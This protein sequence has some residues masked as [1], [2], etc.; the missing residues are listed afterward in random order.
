MNKHDTKKSKIKKIKSGFFSRGY[1]LAKMTLSAGSQ[2]ALGSIQGI[3]QTQEEK[4]DSALK[5]MSNQ[6]QNFSKELGELKGSLMKVG[7]QLSI[8]GEYFFPP[9]INQ[10]LKN[11]QKNSP[12]IEWKEIEKILNKRLTKNIRAQLEIDPEPIGTASL[13]QVHRARI[14]A[15]QEEVVLKIQYPGVAQAIDQ[16]LKFI[17]SMISFGK[18]FS[19]GMTKE[20]WDAIFNELKNILLQEVNYEQERLLMDQYR[21]LL[22][23]DPRFI[24]PRTYP[25]FS[26]KKILCMKYEGGLSVDSKEISEL[27]QDRKNKIA[28]DFLDLFFMELFQMNLIQTDAHFGNYAIRCDPVPSNQPLD[29][30]IL[31]DFGATRSYTQPFIEAYR[32]LVQATSHRDEKLLNEA[33]TELG[34]LTSTDSEEFKKDFKEMCFLIAEPF[35]DPIHK[36]HWGESNL[37]DRLKEKA[38]KIASSLNIRL[39]PKEMISIDRKLGGIFVFLKKLNAHLNGNEI[40]VKRMTESQKK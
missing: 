10:F 29:Q 26:S 20:K 15:T 18:F 39:P 5:I 13:G 28:Y 19:K 23:G 35:Y 11:L 34:F 30:I 24:I 16:D 38:K 32:R 37:P 1:S 22:E 25:E 31:Y 33:G 40:L 12:A 36:Y 14:I 7:Q 2:S 3:F 6:L 27:S 4:K 9:E 8:Y 17:R 21:L